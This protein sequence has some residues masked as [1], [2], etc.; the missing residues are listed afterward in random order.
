MIS[1]KRLLKIGFV[2][3]LQI[4]MMVGGLLGSDVALAYDAQERYNE[5]YEYCMKTDDRGSAYCSQWA[6]PSNSSYDRRPSYD[7]DQRPSYDMMDSKIAKFHDCI[8]KSHNNV[9]SCEQ[10]LFKDN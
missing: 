3:V 8:E 5:R 4:A 9:E 6:G 7:Y 10:I 1:A 2:L